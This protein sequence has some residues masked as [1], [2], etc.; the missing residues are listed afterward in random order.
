MHERMC[1][2]SM[3][4]NGLITTIKRQR[5]APVEW[6]EPTPCSRHGLARSRNSGMLSHAGHLLMEVWRVLLKV[7]N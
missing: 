3:R 1:E 6:N 7:W 5:H 4:C 2:G